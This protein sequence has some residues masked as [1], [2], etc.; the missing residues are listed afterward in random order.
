MKLRPGYEINLA[1]PDIENIDHYIY[2]FFLLTDMQLVRR[3]HSKTKKPCVFL[4]SALPN[5]HRTDYLI[6]ILHNCDARL[7]TC[8]G[9]V[10]SDY[11]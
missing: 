6:E 5:A 8:L 2:D 10:C 1:S 9:D 11:F 4:Y 7:L 3:N